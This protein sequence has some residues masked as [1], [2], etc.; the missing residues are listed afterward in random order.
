MPDKTGVLKK[1]IVA[2]GRE[3]YALRLVS[4][5]AGNLSARLDKNHI[6]ITVT[7][8]CLGALK[9]SDLIKADLNKESETKIKRTSS[10]FTLHRL[11]YKNFP[12]KVAIHCHPPLTN[13]YFAIYPKLKNLTYESKLYLKRVPVV[14]QKGLTMTQPKL[15]I[16]ALKTSNL[17]IVRN[18]GVVCIGDDFKEALYLIEV[19][20]ESVKVA[21]LARLFKK[22][23][24]DDLDKALK[25]SLNPKK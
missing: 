9:Y 5:R 15:V 7:G 18:H 16:G 21:A 4:G 1:E 24:C 13:A 17:V 11:I 12:A 20:E 2:I 19:L 14:E 25:M 8:T 23:G 22:K 6:L 10:E 3:L